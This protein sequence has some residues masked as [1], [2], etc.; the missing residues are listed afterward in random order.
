[1]R[2]DGRF[3]IYGRKERREK[4]TLTLPS[5][6]HFPYIIRMSLLS[7]SSELEDQ[8]ENFYQNQLSPEFSVYSLLRLPR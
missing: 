7:I 8:G 2:G 6:S 3:I 4:T 5:S 1:M